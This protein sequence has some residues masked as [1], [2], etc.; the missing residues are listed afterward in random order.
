MNTSDLRYLHACGELALRKQELGVLLGRALGVLSDM[1][2]YTW[3]SRKCEQVGSIPGTDW[4]YFFHGFECELKNEADG[5]HL[6]YDFGPGGRLDALSG[7][8]VSCFVSG[9]RAP[10]K[11]FPDLREHL[12]QDTVKSQAILDRLQQEGYFEPADPKLCALVRDCTRVQPDGSTRI[13]PPTGTTWE[14]QVDMM[15]ADRAV[16]SL[17][18]RMALANL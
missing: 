4:R 2:F 18:G 1:L 17:A 12:G 10:W 16:L 8:A 15:V 5:R 3:M 6:R 9:S 7:S 13:T 14:T 11:E